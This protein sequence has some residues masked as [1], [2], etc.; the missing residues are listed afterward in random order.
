MFPLLAILT[1]CLDSTL[2]LCTPAIDDSL[3]YTW[4]TGAQTAC[5]T[6]T[7]TDIGEATYICE[8]RTKTFR[9][10]DN[11]MANGDFENYTDYHQQPTGYTSDYEY[12]P[13]DPYGTDLYDKPEY[14]GKSGVYLLSHNA[15]HTW[16]DYANVS[17]HS[18]ELFA[19]FDAAQSGYAWKAS[20]PENPEL[21]ILENG[22]YVFSYWATDLNE[23]S[24]R[25]HP[26]QLQF[27]I[28]Y[29][30]PDGTMRKDSLGEAL[31]L[32]KDNLWHYSQTYWTSPV[33]SDYI[34][35][36]VEDL[37]TYYGVGNDFGLDDII[38]QMVTLEGSE[39]IAADTFQ[40][41]TQDC[42]PCQDFV[43][44]KWN[45]V[46]FADNTSEQ[47][48]SYQWYVDSVAIIG[49]T[50]QFYQLTD[51]I[52]PHLYYVEA[53]MKDGRVRT[54]CVQLFEQFEPSAPLHP[55]RSNRLI[56]RQ[57]HLY[58]KTENALYDILGNRHEL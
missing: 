30:M 50:Q 15:K 19:M 9:T 52:T 41:I 22:L 11:L 32:G 23:A 34:E 29:R 26:A 5:I 25:S 37:N 31:T 55:V 10:T 3:F 6:V 1:L 42:T 7:G 28:R 33:T 51:T 27:T 43:Y 49:A 12:L 20:T 4:N 24:Q 35:I 38:F 16:R 8:A 39:L 44:R 45:D 2:S 18:G 36:G 48:V 56:L 40:V 54:S 58:I 46:L 17:P 14:Q 53:T 21:Q 13:F 57:G 47:F